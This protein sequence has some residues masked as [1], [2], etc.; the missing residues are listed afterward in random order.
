[1]GIKQ[2]DSKDKCPSSNCL[3]HFTCLSDVTFHLDKFHKEIERECPYCDETLPSLNEMLNHID[4]GNLYNAGYK[5]ETTN[6]DKMFRPRCQLYKNRRKHLKTVYN[7][8]ICDAKFPSKEI[9]KKHFKGHEGHTPVGLKK[10]YWKSKQIVNQLLQSVNIAKD[11]RDYKASTQVIKINKE[12]SLMY[13]KKTILRN[14]T[15]KSTCPPANPQLLAISMANHDT[16]EK[17][18]SN[19]VEKEDIDNEKTN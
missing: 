18:I 2:T 6:C 12:H 4:P 9:L 19:I 13:P 7:C 16:I 3:K 15:R 1:M 8:V 17:Y 10:A 14:M 5:C 11:A